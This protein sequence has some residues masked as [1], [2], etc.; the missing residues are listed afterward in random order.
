MIT[1]PHAA[2]REVVYLFTGFLFVHSLFGLS[3]SL[4]L[5][6]LSLFLPFGKGKSFSYEYRCF[7]SLLEIAKYQESLFNNNPTSM[8]SRSKHGLQILSSR[9]LTSSNQHATFLG[10]YKY[11]WSRILSLLSLS[12]LRWDILVLA[13]LCLNQTLTAQETDTRKISYFRG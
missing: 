11:L 2:N 10:F 9:C 6:S 8:I 1:L 13:C 12:S 4:S 7:A 3:L 5:V